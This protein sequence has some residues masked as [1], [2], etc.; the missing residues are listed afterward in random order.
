MIRL[1]AVAGIGAAA[2][3]LATAA[4]GGSM[5][6]LEIRNNEFTRYNEADESPTALG[7][8]GQNVGSWVNEAL[9]PAP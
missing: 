9:E 4:G 5:L 2:L 6:V 8:F 1:A 3:T 7:R